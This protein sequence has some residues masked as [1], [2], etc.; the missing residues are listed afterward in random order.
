MSAAPKHTKEVPKD[1]PDIDTQSAEEMA[2][3]MLMDL[4]LP[5]VE[6]D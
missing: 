5:D 3:S 2:D 4:P 1:V 6:E